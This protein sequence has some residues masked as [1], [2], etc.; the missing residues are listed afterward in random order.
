ML[1]TALIT[2][3]KRFADEVRADKTVRVIVAEPG[4][5]SPLDDG[6][7][8]FHHELWCRIHRPERGA[9]LCHAVGHAGGREP[10]VDRLLSGGDLFWAKRGDA[11][12]VSVN[13]AAS[14][15]SAG[16]ARLTHP[17]FSAV[18]AS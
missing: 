2:E 18:T 10:G 3:L 7:H 9:F 16:S 14:S 12:G 1:D 13:P 11:T 5:Y 4:L 6:A 17:Y 8:T 15:W